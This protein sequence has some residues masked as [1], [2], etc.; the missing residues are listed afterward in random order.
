MSHFSEPRAAGSARRNFVAVLP[1]ILGA[2]G[3]SALC[4][5]IAVAF[6]RWRDDAQHRLLVERKSLCAT[7]NSTACDQLRSAC[8]KRSADGCLALADTYLSAGPR[9]DAVEGAR[10]LTE[11][12]DHNLAEACRRASAIYADGR[13]IERDPERARSLRLRACTFGDKESCDGAQ[14]APDR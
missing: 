3:A 4:V 14:P 8:L 1:A 6:L 10:L 12:C 9:H 13:D 7:G 2:L 5:A 11:A